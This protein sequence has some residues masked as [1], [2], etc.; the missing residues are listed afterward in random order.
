MFCYIVVS[1]GKRNRRASRDCGGKPRTA[2]V[3]LPKDIY[4]RIVRKCDAEGLC[5]SAY[6]RRAIGRELMNGE[7]SRRAV[8]RGQG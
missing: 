4:R 8:S 6:V 3:R 7:C 5:F 1:M 2:S